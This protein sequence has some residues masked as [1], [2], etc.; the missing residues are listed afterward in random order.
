V[1]IAGGRSVAETRSLDIPRVRR[2]GERHGLRLGPDDQEVGGR[3]CVD[4]WVDVETLVQTATVVALT[5][6]EWTA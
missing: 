5:A 4:E 3:E 1:K 2:R 6:A